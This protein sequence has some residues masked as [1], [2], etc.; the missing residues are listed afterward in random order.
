MDDKEIVF[1]IRKLEP[2]DI[3]L[4]RGDSI[5]STLITLLDRGNYSH[6]ILHKSNGVCI[7]AMY[8]YVENIDL[9]RHKCSSKERV[10]IL[11][12]A[13]LEY[14][15]K[16]DAART[17]DK[18]FA[19]KFSLLPKAGVSEDSYNKI[20]CSMLVAYCYQQ[21]G[22][23]IQQKTYSNVTPKDIETDAVFIDVTDSIIT[24]EY[25]S[26]SPLLLSYLEVRDST[27]STKRVQAKLYN[28]AMSQI[29]SEYRKLFKKI[30]HKSNKETS[31]VA[32][33]ST[34]EVMMADARFTALQKV[35]KKMDNKIVKNFKE[36]NFLEHIKTLTLIELYQLEKIKNK[37]SAF[38]VS[39]YITKSITA[40]DD[41]SSINDESDKLI[42]S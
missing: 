39:E 28:S 9:S 1:D 14:N 21:E 4:V 6:A 8:P 34:L 42:I 29:Q 5:G 13:T 37:L 19:R 27:Y 10:C 12:H 30:T 15:K 36:N 38:K 2:L 25:T 11:R 16:A 26:D 3:I 40:I 32:V 35:L 17:I 41:I 33:V 23:N 22:I 20:F 31:I 24:E 18:L 7:E